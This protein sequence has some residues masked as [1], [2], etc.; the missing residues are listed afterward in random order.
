LC[1]ANVVTTQRYTHVSKER[2]QS[3]YLSSHPRA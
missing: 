2:L 3:A 1:H